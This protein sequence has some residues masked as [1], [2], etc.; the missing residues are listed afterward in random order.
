LADNGK[1]LE[2]VLNTDILNA[3]S[4]FKT[5]FTLFSKAD[6]GLLTNEVQI[7]DLNHADELGDCFTVQ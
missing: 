1:R 3:G 2:E 4:Y 5:S 6:K 7:L